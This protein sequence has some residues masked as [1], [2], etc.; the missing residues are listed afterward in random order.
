MYALFE[1]PCDI[2]HEGIPESLR[3]FLNPCF[4]K[5]VLFGGVSEW[6][7]LCGLVLLVDRLVIVI[8]L[9]RLVE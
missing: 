5:S 1:S 2:L 6:S 3:K 9:R 4:D 7:F 8:R